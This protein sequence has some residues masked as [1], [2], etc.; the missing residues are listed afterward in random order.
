MDVTFWHLKRE[1]STNW[2]CREIC[3]L[4]IGFLEND[5]FGFKLSLPNIPIGHNHERTSFIYFS[6]FNDKLL[7]MWFQIIHISVGLK[8][9]FA[10]P[11]PKKNILLVTMFLKFHME[12]ERIKLGPFDKEAYSHSLHS[13]ISSPKKSFADIMNHHIYG[14]VLARNTILL[15]VFS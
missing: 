6:N 11:L 9:L 12:I 13:K 7:M 14:L 4:A 5:I 8:L 10:F 1:P 2:K 3:F 15:S